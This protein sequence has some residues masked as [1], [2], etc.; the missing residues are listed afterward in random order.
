MDSAYEQR[1]QA[2]LMGK[3]YVEGST[4]EEYWNCLLSRKS[5]NRSRN[6]LLVEKT[7]CEEGLQQNIAW[8]NSVNAQY[9]YNDCFQGCIPA[10]V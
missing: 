7:S 4:K 8:Q 1:L 3:T 5:E 6:W 2:E 10:F 9:S